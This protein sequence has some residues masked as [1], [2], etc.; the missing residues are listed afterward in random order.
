MVNYAVIRETAARPL[1]ASPGGLPPWRRDE[2]YPQQREGH[3]EATFWDIHVDHLAGKMTD[4]RIAA[5]RRP[6]EGISLA[7]ANEL[8]RVRRPH[9]RRMAT[10]PSRLQSVQSLSCFP[11]RRSSLTVRCGECRGRRTWTLCTLRG[12]SM[13][14][15][16]EG[17]D[18]GVI[19][20]AAPGRRLGTACQRG[21]E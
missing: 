6:L 21:E 4:I 1:P 3:R 12:A 19:D 8:E 2:I 13:H 20:E 11:R 10:P 5:R 7:A 16:P 17:I 9:P 15:M 18:Y 14:V